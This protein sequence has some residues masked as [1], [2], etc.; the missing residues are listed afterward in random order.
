MWISRLALAALLTSSA[1]AQPFRGDI[2]GTVTDSTGAALV[3]AAVKLENPATGFVRSTLSGASG[4]FLF[5][6]LAAGT[7]KITVTAAGF[8]AKEVA[9][10]EAAVAKTTNIPVQL[11]VAQQTAGDEDSPPAVSI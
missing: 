5:A 1:F 8:Q 10:I 3:D 7:Y 4:N 2:A 9:G 11:S 6:E